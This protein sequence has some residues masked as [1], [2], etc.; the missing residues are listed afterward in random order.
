MNAAHAILAHGI[1]KVAT[2]RFILLFFK[3][4]VVSKYFHKVEDSVEKVTVGVVNFGGYH[5]VHESF[6]TEMSVNFSKSFQ[7]QCFR[8]LALGASVMTVD[9]L[10]LL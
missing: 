1:L 4:L 5:F 10:A 9:P 7:P 6:K 2:I 8:S 3:R